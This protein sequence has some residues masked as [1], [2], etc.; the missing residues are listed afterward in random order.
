MHR[1]SVCP[2]RPHPGCQLAGPGT[3]AGRPPHHTR[4]QGGSRR[5]STEEFGC[6][7]SGSNRHRNSGRCPASLTELISIGVAP[8]EFIFLD[9]DKTGYVKYL[10]LALQLSHPGTV[11]V[12][13]N[14]IRNGAVLDGCA[15]EDYD[16]G[17]R[18]Y[19]AVAAAHPRL[20]SI[21]PHVQFKEK[22]DGM[23]ISRVK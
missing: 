19:N 8:C 21:A 12:A 2:R 4:I 1:N 16:H 20:A 23:T 13:D 5:D 6:G 22:I 15:T 9:A 14:I 3:P 17:A 18:N 11:I 10:E 7:Q